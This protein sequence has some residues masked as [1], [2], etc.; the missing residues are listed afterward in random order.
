MKT[1]AILNLKGGVGKTVTAVNMAAILAE[2][3][4]KRVL[5]VDADSQCNT[6]EFFGGTGTQGLADVLKKGYNELA[7]ENVVQSTDIEGLGLLAASDELMDFDLTAIATDTVD[8]TGLQR[9][10]EQLEFMD[11]YDYVI[12]DCPPAFNA[13]ATAALLAADE[14]VIPIKL[15]AFSLHGMANLTRQIQNMRRINPCLRVAGML[16]TMYYANP[17]FVS[18]LAE[19]HASPLPVF[20]TVIRRSPKVDSM[21]FAQEPLTRYSPRS[22]AGQDYR[23]FVAEY[24]KGG[25]AYGR[26]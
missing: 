5:I 9:L 24:L 26:E 16:P 19:L 2:D 8:A 20:D 22:S 7:Y 11:A 1:I 25:A 23:R 21:T 18:A 13:A 3:Y 10:C 15:D 4:A 14:V 17:S 6:T 12:I